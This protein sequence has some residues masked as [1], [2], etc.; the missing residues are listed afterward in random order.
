MKSGEDRELQSWRLL[1]QALYGIFPEAPARHQ[2][3]A[4]Y[5]RIEVERLRAARPRAIRI[6]EER[7]CADCG[8]EHST[9]WHPLPPRQV[10]AELHRVRCDGCHARRS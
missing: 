8:T 7:S 4:E 2:D 1:G 10:T 3:F 9:G 5:V 6:I